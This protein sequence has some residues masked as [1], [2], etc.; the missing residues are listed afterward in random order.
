MS[1]SKPR[2]ILNVAAHNHTPIG[3]RIKNNLNTARQDRV[4]QN[5]LKKQLTVPSFRM[6]FY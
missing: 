4:G 1:K 6:Y 5:I 3:V 2:L